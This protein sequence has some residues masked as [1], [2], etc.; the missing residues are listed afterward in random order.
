MLI[1]KK[2][3]L[4]HSDVYWTYVILFKRA[5][6][7][8][9]KPCEIIDIFKCGIPKEEESWGSKVTS[10]IPPDVSSQKCDISQLFI[11]HV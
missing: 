9:I 8:I 11:D 6:K 4:T 2:E 10:Q 5:I 3:F 1:V 7:I